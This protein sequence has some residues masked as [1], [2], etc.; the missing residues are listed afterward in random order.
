MRRPSRQA[1]RGSLQT[2]N[3]EGYIT[4]HPSSLQWQGCCTTTHCARSPRLWWRACAIWG[5]KHGPAS[6]TGVC[7]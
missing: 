1:S 5:I 4:T 3:A 7:A 6:Q 2:C